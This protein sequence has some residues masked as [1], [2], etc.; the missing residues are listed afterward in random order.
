MLS[1]DES[2]T[3][4]RAIVLFRKLECQAGSPR[5]K[6]LASDAAWASEYLA[7][8]LLPDSIRSQIRRKTN[9]YNN[10]ESAKQQLRDPSC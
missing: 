7:D 6:G 3:L 5:V 4:E 10:H 8:Y 2:T 9:K 1:L